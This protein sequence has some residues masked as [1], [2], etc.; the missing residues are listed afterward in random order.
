MC[1]VEL[2]KRSGLNDPAKT[3]NY[4]EDNSHTD[5]IPLCETQNNSSL[6]DSIQSIITHYQSLPA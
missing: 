1:N 2:L 5:I 6:D 3:E 4:E